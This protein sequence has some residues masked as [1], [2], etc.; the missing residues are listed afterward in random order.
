MGLKATDKAT[1]RSLFLLFAGLAGWLSPPRQ[2]QE[3]SL[4]L[5]AVH[6]ANGCGPGPRR[7]TAGRAHNSGCRSCSQA[8]PSPPS[9]E[10]SPSCC[11]CFAC[12]HKP[13][14]HPWQG[15]GVFRDNYSPCPQAFKHP[16]APGH[17][18]RLILPFSNSPEVALPKPPFHPPQ[19]P[20]LPAG[21][22]PAHPGSA[23][24][25]GAAAAPFLGCL[26]T[27]LHRRASPKGPPFTAGTILREHCAVCVEKE[28]A[29]E[30]NQ[31]CFMLLSKQQRGYPPQRCGEGALRTS[32]T[33]RWLQQSGIKSISNILFDESRCQQILPV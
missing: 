25:A 17:C 12:S 13:E 21:P 1:P 3:P 16:R 20:Q 8:R 4:A 6:E 23:R 19:P 22:D 9:E 33:F 32:L 5:G 29:A 7:F 27:R 28:K 2:R 11:S 15:D 30:Q 10:D 26:E 18:P 24:A 31:G 14:Q